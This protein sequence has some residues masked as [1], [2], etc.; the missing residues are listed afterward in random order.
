[1]KSKNDVTKKRVVLVG[2]FNIILLESDKN[3]KSLNRDVLQATE[4]AK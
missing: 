3:K 1:M 2:N 4:S